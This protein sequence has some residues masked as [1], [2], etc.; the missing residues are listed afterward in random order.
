[1][2]LRQQIDGRGG[3]PEGCNFAVGPEGVP[4]HAR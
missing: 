2:I 3:T 1:M 4:S